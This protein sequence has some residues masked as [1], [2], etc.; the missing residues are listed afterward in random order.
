MTNVAKRQEEEMIHCLVGQLYSYF[1]P[2]L[3]GA[4]RNFKTGTEVDSATVDGL[5][6]SADL[7]NKMYTEFV[8]EIL[9]H[10]VK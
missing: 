8:Q 9:K 6:S 5:L 4:A 7:G 2:L 1:D 3:V 10:K